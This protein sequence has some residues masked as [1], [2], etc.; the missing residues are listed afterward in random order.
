MGQEPTFEI[1]PGDL[2]RTTAEPAPALRWKAS[3]PGDLHAPSDVPWGGAFGTPG[4]DTGYALKLASD[5]V[6][7]L[8]AGESRHNVESTLVLIMGARASLFGKAPSADDLG[9]GLILLGLDSSQEIPEAVMARLMESRRHWAP[10]VAHSKSAA[11]ALAAR[12]TPQLL[13]WSLADLRQRLAL[14]EVPLSP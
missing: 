10:R 12:L 2:P 14:G 3:R 1:S 8:D 6:Y 4:P 5:A 7:E 11:R 13:G 9:F